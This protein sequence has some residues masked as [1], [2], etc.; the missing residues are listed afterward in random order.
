M[1]LSCTAPVIVNEVRGRV[2]PHIIICYIGV[3]CNYESIRDHTLFER[4]GGT[5]IVTMQF[6]LGVS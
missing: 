5:C 1:G 2:I 3:E 4:S 6:S